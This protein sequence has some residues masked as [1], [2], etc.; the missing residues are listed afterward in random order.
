MSLPCIYFYQFLLFVKKNESIFH[1]N[2]DLHNYITRQDI[3]I[4]LRNLT[5][6][7]PTHSFICEVR[8]AT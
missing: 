3:G 4:T 5:V 7:T 8:V 1:L 2:S 6:L